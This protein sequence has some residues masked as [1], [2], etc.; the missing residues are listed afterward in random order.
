[1][2]V[3]A[4]HER[5]AL[6]LIRD[7][8]PMDLPPRVLDIGAN[9]G[10]YTGQ[11]LRCWRD[12][13]V[14]AYEP[15]PEAR[16]R[17]VERFEGYLGVRVSSY[18]LSSHPGF[19]E[20]RA[21]GEAC[22]LA[23]MYDRPDAENYHG[24]GVKLDKRHRVQLE[25]VDRVVPPGRRFMLAKIDVEGHELD[26][27]TGAVN[28]LP[29]IDLIQFEYN[30]CAGVADVRFTDLYDFLHE[31]GFRLYREHEDGLDLVQEPSS[32]EWK[33]GDSA[34]DY[35]AVSTECVWWPHNTRASA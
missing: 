32:H 16:R 7:A 11:V 8:W 3:I 9:V 27:L 34:R 24:T 18:A 13:I 14:Y 1:M 10:E 33:A 12:A 25:T 6:D 19:G 28:T 5:V 35:L 17:Y 26:V 31:H 15:Q 30:D 22:V 21:S 4:E 2:S 20:L 29:M 23:T